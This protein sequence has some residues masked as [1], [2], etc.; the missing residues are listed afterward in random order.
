MED[1]ENREKLYHDLAKAMFAVE[2]EGFFST[3][4]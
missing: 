4:C 2:N 1:Q 3:E